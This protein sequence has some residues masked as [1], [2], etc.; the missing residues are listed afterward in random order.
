MKHIV[1]NIHDENADC[2]S[3]L[4]NSARF[5]PLFE[6]LKGFLV[7]L[8]IKGE[9]THISK[10]QELGCPSLGRVFTQ[11]FFQFTR[12]AGILPAAREEITNHLG[13]T[14]TPE[15]RLALTMPS[16]VVYEIFDGTTVHCQKEGRQV[17]F[18]NVVTFVRCLASQPPLQFTSSRV[19]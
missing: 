4:D 17:F 7:E 5:R 18:R 14:D 19:A 13:S 10:L 9:D 3:R 15:E 16:F 8:I 2:N 6:Q 12:M 11:N 1:G